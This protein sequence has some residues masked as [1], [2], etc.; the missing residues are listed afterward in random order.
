VSPS[1]CNIYISCSSSTTCFGSM[2]PSAT[3]CYNTRYSIYSS[4]ISFQKLFLFTLPSNIRNDA[5]KEPL[6]AYFSKRPNIS[7]V[8]N[9]FLWSTSKLPWL[10]KSVGKMRGSQNVPRIFLYTE[11][12]LHDAFVPPGQ[13]VNCNFYEQVLQ[14][15]LHTVRRERS[16][17][18]QQII[19]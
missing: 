19:A 16:D 17:K 9:C 1:I 14:R 11:G 15:L 5:M 13:R 6:V 3:G 12:L 2:Q 8:Q 4:T 10:M 7:C 18:W